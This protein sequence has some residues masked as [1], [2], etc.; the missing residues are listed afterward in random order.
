[1]SEG[2]GCS[3]AEVHFAF[4]CINLEENLVNLNQNVEF[5]L[6]DET[7]KSS[8]EELS[9]AE[10]SKQLGKL[11][12]EQADNQRIFDWIEVC[13]HQAQGT[14]LEPGKGTKPVF[15]FAGQPGR[16]ADVLQHV[17]QSSDDVRLSVSHRL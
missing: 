9:S 5:T 13:A 2:C 17:R 10:M 4:C 7:E 8:K 15:L 14:E 12:Q 1:M 3:G 11:I 6:G 16:A